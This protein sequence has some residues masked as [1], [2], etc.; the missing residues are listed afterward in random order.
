MRLLGPVLGRPAVTV[1]ALLS[2]GL[3]PFLLE[4][5]ENPH[6]RDATYYPEATPGSSLRESSGTPFRGEGAPQG[7]RKRVGAGGRKQPVPLY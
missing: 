5:L 7:R 4:G 6:R 3:A 1:L 2:Q